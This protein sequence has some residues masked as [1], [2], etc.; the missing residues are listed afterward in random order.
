M[1]VTKLV[2]WADTEIEFDGPL[3]AHIDGE[4]VRL[5]DVSWNGLWRLHVWRGQE[6]TVPT[7]HAPGT[8]IELISAPQPSCPFGQSA[9]RHSMLALRQTLCRRSQ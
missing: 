7:S 9:I 1:T 5:A 4:V 6:G 3:M 2:K 8:P